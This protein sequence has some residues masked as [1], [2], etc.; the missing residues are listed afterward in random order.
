MIGLEYFLPMIITLVAIVARFDA[1]TRLLQVDVEVLLEKYAAAGLVDKVGLPLISS[2]HPFIRR[3]VVQNVL[4]RL[5]M[6][7]RMTWRKHR[8]D[9]TA[10]SP[11]HAVMMEEDIGVIAEGAID[12]P[13]SS[14][15]ASKHELLIARSEPAVVPTESNASAVPDS[16]AQ[17]DTA[18]SLAPTPLPI[19]PS[20]VPAPVE[21]P[22]SKKRK[23]K[24]G[25][26]ID[27]IFGTV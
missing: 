6:D 13:N 19:K 21:K 26:A 24:R 12:Q 27:D 15:E 4:H 20:F 3:C 7:L 8:L 22:L 17:V 1:L 25:D 18:S 5:P 10:A 2:A 14:V 23:K 9:V 11:T 16:T